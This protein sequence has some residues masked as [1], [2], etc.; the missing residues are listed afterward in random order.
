M[1]LFAPQPKKKLHSGG[2][3]FT[4]WSRKRSAPPSS[5]CGADPGCT[6]LAAQQALQRKNHSGVLVQ[7]CHSHQ[8]PAT[9]P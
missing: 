3:L 8:P 7:P 6:P 2:A 5:P 4:G 1:T 9:A